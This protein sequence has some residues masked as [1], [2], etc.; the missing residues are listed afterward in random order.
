MRHLVVLAFVFGISACGTDSV[1]VEVPAPTLSDIQAKVFT[2]TCALSGCHDAS[3]E[4]G[5][6][7]RAGQSYANL[8]SVPAEKSNDDLLRVKPGDA[9]NSFLIR[10][11]VRPAGGEGTIMPQGTPDGLDAEVV[12]AIKTWINNGA[13]NN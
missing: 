11:M 7:L 5:L 13:E 9:E 10:K 12:E 1:V 6:D 8:V 4:G 3:A 2:P